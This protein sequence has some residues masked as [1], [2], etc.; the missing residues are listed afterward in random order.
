MSDD[1]A[2]SKSRKRNVT[3]YTKTQASSSEFQ[4]DSTV[5]FGKWS[6]SKFYLATVK[7][8]TNFLYTEKQ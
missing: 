7:V 6:S 8:G 4:E 5:L 3:L 1:L 2:D